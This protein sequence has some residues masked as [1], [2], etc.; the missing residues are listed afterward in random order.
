MVSEVG[1]Y[2]FSRSKQGVSS[3]P[4]GSNLSPELFAFSHPHEWPKW[5]RRFERFRSASGLSGKPEET[6]V[7][8]LIYTMGD[9]EADD[10]LRSF[11][12]SD[13]DK[14]KYDTVMGKF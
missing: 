7:N 11:S 13:E 8:T 10:I 2:P 3:R 14:K 4:H 5:I 6:Q 12:L 9:D 1:S